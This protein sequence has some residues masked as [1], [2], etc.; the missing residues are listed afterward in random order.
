MAVAATRVATAVT[1]FK[2]VILYMA[3]P[4]SMPIGRMGE[5]RG[6]KCRPELIS[7]LGYRLASNEIISLI[8]LGYL[9]LSQCR[10][11]GSLV[12]PEEG[13]K[14]GKGVMIP[15]PGRPVTPG[16]HASQPRRRQPHRSKRNR[17]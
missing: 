2:Q 16:R 9:F 10:K 17:A 12:T 1:V 15:E 14:T 4:P 8:S 6:S 5:C 7:Q 11:C 3:R 13:E